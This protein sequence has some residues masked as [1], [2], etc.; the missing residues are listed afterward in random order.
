M[1]QKIIH[2][3]I[4]QELQCCNCTWWAQIQGAGLVGTFGICEN[5]KS[6][7]CYHVITCDHQQC[8]YK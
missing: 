2:D 5:H 8:E 1:T 4:I 3:C 7:H 6:D